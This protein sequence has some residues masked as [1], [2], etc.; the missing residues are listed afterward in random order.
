M[1]GVFEPNAVAE[2]DFHARIGNAWQST[3]PAGGPNTAATMVFDVSRG[4]VVAVG[5]GFA[6][7]TA[8]TWTFDGTS[9][10]LRQP[11][12]SPPARSGASIALDSSRQV[13][14]LFGGTS[15]A[16]LLNDT[17]EWNGSTWTQVP[18]ASQP[19]ALAWSPMTY[20]TARL[21][22]VLLA[23]T[24]P[25]GT[26]PGAGIVELWEYD[27]S[28]WVALPAPPASIGNRLVYTTVYDEAQAQTMI[29]HSS[30]AQSRY[31]DVWA[32]NGS[33]W[34]QLP[35]FG[36]SPWAHG[37]AGVATNPANGELVMFGGI[38]ANLGGGTLLDELWSFAG[39]GWT[40]ATTSTIP[41]R[42]SPTVWWQSNQAYVFGGSS[43]VSALDD[44]WQWNG[45]TSTQ[46][47][48]PVAPSARAGA[49]VAVDLVANVA[50]LFGG[51][52][53]LGNGPLDDTWLFDGTTWQQANPT[54]EP[55]ARSE[56]AMAYDLG[57]NRVVLFGGSL[58]GFPSTAADTWEWDG[59][60]WQQVLTNTAP[61]PFGEM[62]YDFGA[63]RIVFATAAPGATAAGELWT[64]D[65]SNWTKL[66]VAGTA[67]NGPTLYSFQPVPFTSSTG[68]LSVVGGYG[69]REL[70][71]APARVEVYGSGCGGIVPILAA[72][73]LPNPGNASFGLETTRVPSGAPVVFIGANNS[74]SLA[75]LGCTLLVDPLGVTAVAIAS[76][77]GFAA[78]NVPLPATP[79]LIG[80]AFHFQSAAL[81]AAGPSGLVF[82][83]GLRVNIGN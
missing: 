32:W 19:T 60:N 57:R 2:F 79:A 66:Q 37:D 50:V 30:D 21:K 38:N 77:S 34:T 49:G 44:T 65:G 64:Y 56:H 73:S 17:W 6:G 28:N 4:E 15:S 26:N 47:I 18:T 33:T 59:S 74:V 3:Q 80:S 14:V 78:L 42:I 68:R 35:G 16:G 72:N 11:A 43:W 39:N 52:T 76:S 29:L 82:T 22:M 27:G 1:L 75:V 24:Q 9:W 71:D 12:S 51:A 20:D 63:N 10:A 83:A 5:L 36:Q 7:L 67:G 58:S 81:S 40:L 55:P 31:D 53:S 61:P 13:V 25:A 69:V 46:L 70:V 23:N 54:T 45:T 8:M 41:A 62:A 48:T